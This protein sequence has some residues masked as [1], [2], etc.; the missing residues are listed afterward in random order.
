MPIDEVGV[1]STT[2]NQYV[3]NVYGLS[4]QNYQIWCGG[5]PPELEET[6]DGEL[7]SLTDLFFTWVDRDETQPVSSYKYTTTAHP[8]TPSPESS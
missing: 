3:I 6:A 5:I 8:C 4:G 2:A 7:Q 1:R